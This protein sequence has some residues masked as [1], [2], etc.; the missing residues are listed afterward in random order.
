MST[1]HLQNSRLCG[2]MLNCQWVRRKVHIQA[3]T[4][5]GLP[6]FWCEYTMLRNN[7]QK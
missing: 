1:N 7:L 6:H 4:M 3:A 2:I 5:T